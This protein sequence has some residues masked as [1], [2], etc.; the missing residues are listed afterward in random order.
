MRAHHGSGDLCATASKVE[1]YSESGAIGLFPKGNL[2]IF[3]TGDGFATGD[4]DGDGLA[5]I[6]IGRSSGSS[7]AKVFVYDQMTGQVIR[8]IPDAG[9]HQGDK[10]AV[11]GT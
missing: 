2:D 9:F 8:T 3:D 10:L 6:V 11:G 5:E 4:V 1:V 7:A